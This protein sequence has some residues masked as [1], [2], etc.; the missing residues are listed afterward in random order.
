[1]NLVSPMTDSGKQGDWRILR[2]LTYRSPKGFALLVDS[3]AS[4][5]ATW[6][7]NEQPFEGQRNSKFTRD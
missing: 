4:I 3:W 2:S 6:G 1:M 5:Y 7:G